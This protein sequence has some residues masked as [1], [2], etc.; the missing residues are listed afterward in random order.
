[1]P[2][3]QFKTK[4]LLGSLRTTAQNAF[5]PLVD[6]GGRIVTYHSLDT[7]VDGDTNRIYNMSKRTFSES[8]DAIE[9][10]R[11]TNPDLEVKPFGSDWTSGLSLT[12][13][14]GYASTLTVAA[15][16]LVEYGFPFHVFVSPALMQSGDKRF[17]DRHSLQEL[18]RIPGVTIGA[19]GYHHVPLGT[20]PEQSRVTVLIDARRWL[21]DVIQQ[22]INTVS[23]PFGDTPPGIERDVMAA[24][25]E[26]AACS[27][28]GFNNIETSPLMLNRLD[29]WDGDSSRIVVAKILGHWNWMGRRSAT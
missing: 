7:P 14:D 21:E 1:V 24:G 2:T 11:A 19:H 12:F 6:N 29:L 4:R 3:F 25:Y 17:L 8:L 28:W 27:L 9:R 15:S 20:I 23:Y 16:K 26:L 5:S 18:A 22:P 13:D 10:L